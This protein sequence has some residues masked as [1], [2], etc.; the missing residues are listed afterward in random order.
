MNDIHSFAQNV[1]FLS[2]LKFYSS[3]VAYCAV[4]LSAL[5]AAG[6]HAGMFRRAGVCLSVQA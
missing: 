1:T 2:L 4:C 5:G 6:E 3:A